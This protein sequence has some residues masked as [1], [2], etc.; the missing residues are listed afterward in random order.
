MNYKITTGNF[1][2]SSNRQSAASYN[3][4]RPSE[5]RVGSLHWLRSADEPW[6]ENIN[7][8]ML[9]PDMASNQYK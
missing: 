2:T 5:V 9:K 7:I 6:E 4:H 3:E 1:L 8:S